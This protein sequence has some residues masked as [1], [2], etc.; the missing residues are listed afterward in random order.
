MGLAGI[1]DRQ[2]SRT[3]IAQV[4]VHTWFDVSGLVSLVNTIVTNEDFKLACTL[5]SVSLSFLALPSL[6]WRLGIWFP[7]TVSL[8]LRCCSFL[9][10][11]LSWCFLFGEYHHFLRFLSLLIL[12]CSCSLF[13]FLY[14]VTC[15]SANSVG[16]KF[17]QTWGSFHSVFF[18]FY[19]PSQSHHHVF[20][21]WLQQLSPLQPFLLSFSLSFSD[22]QRVRAEWILSKCW[23]LWNFILK[24]R[25]V[26]EFFLFVDSW[27]SKYRTFD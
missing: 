20:S 11:L 23:L 22:T 5:C 9:Q 21:R 8:T 6:F 4:S 14:S 13:V 17:C 12:F 25:S 7:Q 26:W 3:S 27:I 1:W 18:P 2:D 24:C 19:Y 15:P 16:S 10:T